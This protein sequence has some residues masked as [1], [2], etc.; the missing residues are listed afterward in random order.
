LPTIVTDLDSPLAT[1]SIADGSL[2]IAPRGLHRLTSMVRKLEIPL[3]A[4]ESVRPATPEIL[5]E[6]FTPRLTKRKKGSQIG[7]RYRAGAFQ[8]WKGEN[9]WWYLVRKGDPAIELTLFGH[10]YHQVVISVSDPEHAVR[11]IDASRAVKE[12]S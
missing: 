11:V 6:V 4:I 3:H 2:W 8:Y 5:A 9:W 1:I 7:E 12:H 10:R